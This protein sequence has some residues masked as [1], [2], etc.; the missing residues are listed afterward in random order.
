MSYDSR[1][2][3]CPICR[4]VAGHQLASYDAGEA[5]QAFVPRRLD[6]NR[7]AAL[8][9]KLS[10]LWL[11]ARCTLRRCDTCELIYADPFVSGDAEFYQ[12]AFPDAS[13]PEQKW[14]YDRTRRALGERGLSRPRVLEIGAGT[15][16]FLKQMLDEGCAPTSLQAFEFSE[17]GRTA[18]ERL[19][20]S[21]HAADLRTVDFGHTYDI[22]CM[23]QVLE[24][25][26]DFD[27]VFE[28][29]TRIVRPG[30]HA[31]IATPNAAWISLNEARR[32]LL[33]MPPNHIS[34]WS[35]VSFA[36]LAHRFGWHLAACDLEPVSRI[37][38]AVRMFTDRYVR[39]ITEESFWESRTAELA[40][41][42]GNRAVA[43][44]I[45]ASAALTSPGC[46]SAAL[47]ATVVPATPPNIWTHL[48]RPGET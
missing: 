22:V 47:R 8:S 7:H 24:H 9:R 32:L 45:K 31:F 25:L 27:G 16:A 15:G 37:R 48:I 40:M 35:P 43:R 11:G 2:T 18:I 23:F 20:I 28:V 3:P 41:R 39:L 17:S 12:L 6:P 36:A 1:V 38:N 34:R 19:G 30:G 44:L 26:D 33:D 46:L 42:A 4:D 10:L 29:L 13:Y 5:A 21:C 14:E